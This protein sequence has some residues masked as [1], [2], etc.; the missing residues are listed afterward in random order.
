MKFVI[1]L[2]RHETNTFSPVPTQLHDFRRGTASDGPAYGEAARQACEGTNSAA[3]AYLDLAREMGAEVEFALCANA[4]PSGLVTRQAFE[5]LCDTVIQSVRQ[6]CD[7]V[8]LDLHGA[9][10]AEGYPDAEGELLRR[11][12]ACT[13]EGLPIGVALDFH[14]N[15]SAELIR[16]A[17]V[18]AGYCTY[19][20]I[21]V[22]DT[23]VRVG[24]SIRALLEQRS[25]P[26]VLWR[27]LPM[28][29]HMLRQTPAAQPMKDIMD[30][31]MQAERDNDVRNASVFGGFPLS[32]IPYAGLSIVI[33]AEQAQ[34]EAAER[35][36]DELC[37]MAW[38][39]RADFVF[40]SEPVADSIARAKRLEDGPVILVD[41]GDNCGAGGITDVMD[42]LEEVLRQ[43]LEDVVAGPFC[44][45]A[46]VDIL[47]GKG[48]GAEVAVDVGGKI[49][50]PALG[51]KGKPLRLSGVVE[52]LTDGEYTV[53]GP[54]FTGMR[55]SLGRTAVLRVG[56]AR[57]FIS[58][59]PQEPYDTGV[60]T[61]A[62]VDPA[63]SRYVLLKSR[64]HFR[65]GF[66]PLAR[67]VVLVGGPGVCSSDY[68]LF[69]F[70]HLSRPIYP[71]DAEAGLEHADSW[72]LDGPG[73]QAQP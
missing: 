27:R 14:A 1:A 26:V 10:V 41:H 31:A 6:G 66:G 56:S 60:F 44:D 7:A 51:L 63:Q 69:P 8:L 5:S 61:H 36:L 68:A 21:D 12:R 40:P 25:Q 9:M 18:I 55:L 71:L 16:H 72:P 73:S 15:F 58:E 24:R 11:I 54:M 20:H 3:A 29:T 43:G 22:Y 35:L 2:V 50:M 38:S 53:T 30:R 45:P 52:K 37:G 70:K 64:Q 46:T 32:D 13:P 17:D 67:H 65:A 28:L 62:G 33:V 49:D 57:I 48:A 59:R 47:F 4:V 19:P 42:V 23:G 34:R 39:R